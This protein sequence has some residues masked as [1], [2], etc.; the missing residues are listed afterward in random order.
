MPSRP[1]WVIEPVR[2]S[3]ALNSAESSPAIRQRFLQDKVDRLRGQWVGTDGAILVNF[4]EDRPGGDVVG[5]HPLVQVNRRASGREYEGTL[6]CRDGF[7][8]AKGNVNAAHRWRCRVYRPQLDGI[9][10]SDLRV[11]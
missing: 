2:S 6:A 3:W 7:R 10:R 4:P 5:L 9:R 1:D 8:T 11:S